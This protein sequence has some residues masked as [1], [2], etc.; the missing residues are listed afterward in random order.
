MNFFYLN[1]RITLTNR[2]QKYY[3]YII[4]QD[5]ILKQNY[6]TISQL[7]SFKKIIINTSSKLYLLDKKYI[8]P[9]LLGLEIIAGQKPKLTYSKKSI[10]CFKIRENQLLGCKV[11]LR[12]P[13]LYLFLDSL[14]TV[15]LPRLRNFSGIPLKS[16]DS[17][18]CSIEKTGTISLGFSD[19]MSFPEL[20]NHF[21]FFE[22]F[23]GLNINF[24]FS[25]S[26][27]QE[28]ILLYSAFQLPR[29]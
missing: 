19:L 9:S 28:I 14:F 18:Q 29:I 2:F 27:L 10:A 4:S 15:I 20:E 24:C 12:G 7:P 22:V 6:N 1:N 5:L 3:H 26:N 21:E 8:I 25:S 11:T 13:R 17:S 23:K 16:F